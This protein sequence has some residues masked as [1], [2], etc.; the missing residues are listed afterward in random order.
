MQ[1]REFASKCGVL[2]VADRLL[3]MVIPVV[4]QVDIQKQH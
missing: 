4:A 3:I 2:V 1:Q